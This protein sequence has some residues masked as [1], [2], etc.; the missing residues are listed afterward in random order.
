MK[1]KI[2]T[3]LCASLLCLSGLAQ[4]AYPSKNI[5]L[6]V[7]FPP[8][9]GTDIL[10]RLLAK[11]IGE[12]LNANVIVEN[13]PGA[14]GNIGSSY[15][16][17]SKPDGHTLLVATTAQTISA[18]LYKKPIYNL[19]KDLVAVSGIN[20]VPLMMITRKNFGAKNI[21]EFIDL[22]KKNPGKITFA[23]P[24]YGTSAHMA[25]E[26]LSLAAGIKI[27]HVP[28]QGAAPV[29]NDLMGGQVDV[30]FDLL[31]TAKGYFTEKKVDAIGMTTLNRTRLMPEVSTLSEQNKESLGKFNE[32][33]WNV[34]MAPSGTPSE[35][36]N[37][38][39]ETMK[40]ILS[41]ESV[42]KKL[43]EI[44]STPIWLSPADSQSFIKNDIE[45]WMS[46]QKNANLDKI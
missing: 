35:V 13:K 42:I 24:G 6:V 21:N 39:N 4:A 44:G 1:F 27:L 17:K 34:L 18:A 37:K 15:V 32:F 40:N 26:V 36:V 5:T 43:E 33:A 8:G 12:K 46:I 23:S 16:A 22:A 41:T 30:T 29:L 38:L 19:S 7:P 20:E 25:G 14:A 28:Y 45:K 31:T 9:G 10:G 2:K 11:E 3:T